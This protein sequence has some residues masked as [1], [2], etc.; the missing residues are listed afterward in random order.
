MK[1]KKMSSWIMLSLSVVLAFT[2]TACNSSKNNNASESAKSSS[3]PTASAA[4]STD[5]ST[6]SPTTGADHSKEVKLVGY[7]LGEAPKGMPE[8]MASLNEKLK[9]D[10]NA[11]LEINYIGWGDIASKYPLILAAGE[12]VDF[13]FTADW[14]FYVQEANKGSF[15]ELTSDMFQKNMPKY[16]AKQDPAAYKAALVNGKQFMIPTTT[17]DRKVNVIVLRKDIMEKAGLTNPTKMSELEPYFAEI[18]KDYPNMIPLN[19]DSQYDLPTPF[20]DLVSEKF[21]YQGAPFDSGDPSSVGNYTDNEDPTGKVLSMTDEPVQSAYKYA[22][23]IMKKWYEAGYVNKNPYAN[24]V[25]S[26][27]NFPEGKSGVAFGNSIDIQA[28]LAACKEK[29]IDTYIMPV[30]SPTGHAPS[31]SWLNNG[32]AIAASSKNPDRAMEALDLIMQDESYVM[33]AYYGIEGK[34]Y[35]ITSDGKLGL[36]DG[37]KA[38]DNTYPP[39][40]AGFW[41]VNK[42]FFK[43][44][45]DWTDSYIDLN[46]KV[47]SYLA[48]IPYLGF[49]FN[50]DN[51]KTEIANLKN[52]STQYFLPFTVGAI[53]DVDS[54]FDQLVS[55]MKAAG[56][57]K[58]KT[59]LEAQ[60]SA[61]LASKK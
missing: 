53:K 38:A 21:A 19:L 3:K 22:A 4:A 51:V 45:V 35:V 34:N 17:P 42:D 46:N 15:M 26:K 59:E 36:P 13:I 6:A 54:S 18:K 5:T 11:T 9:K 37:L 39:D 8:V 43:P 33:N 23:G 44:S 56:V 20:G 32:V 49:S 24:K 60:A 28:T 10:I 48:P 12:N 25:R 61:F 29:G 14:N 7:L 41:F 2:L 50:S 16:Y 31:N 40:A 1:S 47:K 58:V 55:K 52:V 57:D 27:D 30:L